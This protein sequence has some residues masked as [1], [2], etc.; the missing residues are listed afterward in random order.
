MSDQ[1][2]D[3]VIRLENQIQ[4]QLQL[5]QERAE[6]W[7]DKVR[8][9]QQHLLVQAEEQT[10]LE[11]E[12]DLAEARQ[13]AEQQAAALIAA[14][15]EYCSRLEEFSDQELVEVLRHQL[16]SRLLPETGQS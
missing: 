11:R 10:G 15:M 9:E 16:V 3:A 7:L 8:Q 4:Q 5:E 14:E 12:K 6:G 13:R 2:L 1:L